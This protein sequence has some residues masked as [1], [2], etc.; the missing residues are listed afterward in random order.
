MPA[1]LEA[2]VQELVEVGAGQAEHELGQAEGGLGVQVLCGGQGC[3]DQIRHLAVAGDVQAWQ[4]SFLS[5][6]YYR[7]RAN[8]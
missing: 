6:H 4:A 7:E 3:V 5:T 2:D 8:T 1:P